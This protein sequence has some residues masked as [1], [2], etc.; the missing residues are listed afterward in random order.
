VR[1]HGLGQVLL[2]VLLLQVDHREEAV[3]R[4][5]RCLHAVHALAAV[6]RIA[7]APGQAVGRDGRVHADLLQ[8]FHGAAREDDGA[9][10]L[11]D[12]QLGFE[13]HAGHAQARQ[14]QRGK[15]ADRAGADDDDFLAI[16]RRVL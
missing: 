2:Q 8:D 5:V 9:A 16:L 14:L 6:E 13:Q 15:Q 3:V 4:I 1:Q 12:L 11:G 10:A 7:K